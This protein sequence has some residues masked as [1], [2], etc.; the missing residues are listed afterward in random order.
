MEIIQ[1]DKLEEKQQPTTTKVKNRTLAI[2]IISIRQSRLIACRSRLLRNVNSEQIKVHSPPCCHG[3]QE[4]NLQEWIQKGYYNPIPKRRPMTLGELGC[5]D[6][7]RRMWQHIVQNKETKQ[8]PRSTLI[9]E[10]D[11]DLQLTLHQQ[12]VIEQCMDYMQSHPEVDVLFLS[13]T[14]QAKYSRCSRKV[15]HFG[16]ESSSGRARAYSLW[17]PLM[18]YGLH[19]YLVSKTG[20]A[21][22]L[23]L[24]DTIQ[25]PA[26]IFVSKMHLQ[27]KIYALVLK[28]MLFSVLPSTYSDTQYYLTAGLKNA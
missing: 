5:M 10:D 8:Q 21:K 24:S 12:S 16:R 28:P 18:T 13:R 22:L 23:S 1:S 2:Y 4:I 19:G 20:A 6:S 15:H 14:K 11:A 9:L 27:K 17:E 3:R 26:D 25:Y 7:H